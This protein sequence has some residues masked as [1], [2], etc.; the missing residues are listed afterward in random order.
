MDLLRF[1]RSL[2]EFLYEVMTWLLLYP[3]TLWRVVR[4]PARMV[5]QTE[6]EL[7]AREDDQFIDLVSPPLF[8]IL[9]LL[10]AHALE[11]GMHANTAA[12]ATTDLGK[13]IMASDNNLLIF[14]TIIFSLFPLLM[15]QGL[16]RRQGKPL[17]RKVLRRP[18]YLQCYYATPLALFTSAGVSLRHSPLV[19]VQ[20]AAGGL[21]IAGLIWYLAAETNWFRTQLAIGG[22]RAFGLALKFFAIGVVLSVL[23]ALA[24]F[25]LG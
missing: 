12:A 4:H 24:I 2:E 23:I 5:I 7:N 17:N 1:F 25:G 16:L 13:A 11:L 6:A 18:F 3:S 22:L 20:V 21:I 9:S 15:A 14:R 19:A 10:L 8:L